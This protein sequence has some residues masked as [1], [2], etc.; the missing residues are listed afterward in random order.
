MNQFE[1]KPANDLLK[2]KIIL[3]TGASAG[4][5][6]AASITF[7]AHGATVLLLGRD[8]EQLDN[9]YD[10]I[11]SAGYPQPAIIPLHLERATEHDYVMLFE[12]I[13][14]TFGRLDGLLHNAGILG[15]LTPIAHY[16]EAT[17]QQVMQVNV[18]APYLLTKAMMPLLK[19]SSH[20]SVIFTSSSVGR[21]GRAHWGAYSVSKFATEGMMQILAEEVG[22]ISGVRFNSLNPGATRTKMRAT[23]Y[24]AEHPEIN[25]RPEEIMGTYLFLMGD[26]SIGVNGQEYDAQPPKN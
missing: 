3:V 9:V 20:S 23:A 14:E 15:E 17:W 26:E 19:V 25:R 22:E 2:G 18:T 16:P 1:Y 10:E 11:E 4:I 12:K 21:K 24:P 13:D 6:R 7:A 8:Q 5:G